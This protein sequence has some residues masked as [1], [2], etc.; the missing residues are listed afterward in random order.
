MMAAEENAKQ[1]LVLQ[2][3]LAPMANAPAQVILLLIGFVL[4]GALAPIAN[5]QE[6]AVCHSALAIKHQLQNRLKRNLAVLQL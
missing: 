2:T 4:V 6:N 5:K 3:Q 1:A